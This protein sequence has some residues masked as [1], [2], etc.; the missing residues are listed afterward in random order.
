M[1]KII[2]TIIILCIS[3]IANAQP[4]L[5]PYLI[6]NKFILAD[7]NLNIVGTKAYN[8]LQPISYQKQL[9]KFMEIDRVDSFYYEKDKKWFYNNREAHGLIM[10]NKEILRTTFFNEFMV[11]GNYLIHAKSEN[12]RFIRENNIEYSEKI[13]ENKYSYRSIFPGISRDGLDYW[14]KLNRCQT[15]FTFNGENIFKTY[16]RH[17]EVIDVIFE[18]GNTVDYYNVEENIE[19]SKQK[20]RFF[21]IGVEDGDHKSSIAQYNVAKGKIDK[22]LIKDIY[23]IKSTTN[24]IMN[25]DGILDVTTNEGDGIKKYKLTL[26]NAG[27]SLNLIKE[28]KD[29]EEQINSNRSVKVRDVSKEPRVYVGKVEEPPLRPEIYKSYDKETTL[30]KQETALKLNYTKY[31]RYTTYKISKGYYRDTVVVTK[32]INTISSDYKYRKMDT[33]VLD[34]LNI[35]A[36]PIIIDCSTDTVINDT[37]CKFENSIIAY[38]KNGLYKVQQQFINGTFNNIDSLLFYKLKT[39]DNDKCNNYAVFRVE[40]QA[41]FGLAAANDI[42]LIPAIYDSINILPDNNY[43]YTYTTPKSKELALPLVQLYKDGYCMLYDFTKDKTV[44]ENITSARK[45]YKN[46][47]YN[48]FQETKMVAIKQNNVYRVV[49]YDPINGLYN[50]LP[51]TYTYAPNIYSTLYK[52]DPNNFNVLILVDDNNEFKCYALPSGKVFMKQ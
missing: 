15:F 1:Y 22:W 14:N 47:Y 41:Y 48:N 35:F 52:Q 34:T 32:I 38:K 2:N 31:V 17:A 46:S 7:T 36:S 24:S 45:I 19:N 37:N 33:I 40:G 4:V 11:V 12:S 18:N 3:I 25:P 8:Q 5:I 51:A 10:D 23:K 27:Y 26:S 20:V 49:T 30:Q 6:N 29:Q 28:G 42:P 43:S 50:M 44:V 21:L 16:Y 13:E 9:Y 39:N